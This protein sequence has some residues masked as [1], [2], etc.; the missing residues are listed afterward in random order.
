MF[1]EGK[2]L[3]LR[4]R[5]FLVFHLTLWVTCRPVRATWDSKYPLELGRHCI[6]HTSITFTKGSTEMVTSSTEL[7]YGVINTSYQLQKGLYIKLLFY[8]FGIRFRRKSRRVGVSGVLFSFF[9][10]SGFSWMWKRWEGDTPEADID[11]DMADSP[12]RR[13]RFGLKIHTCIPQ[14]KNFLMKKRLWWFETKGSCG[15]IH[16]WVW[17]S[18]GMDDP[19]QRLSNLV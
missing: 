16:R 5:N 1:K 7:W 15:C 11:V 3:V 4:R 12:A 9:S 18:A 8:V 14:N 17:V 13:V 10:G 6:F 19:R 2:C